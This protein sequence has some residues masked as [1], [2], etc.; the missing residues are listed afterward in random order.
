LRFSHGHEKVFAFI[1]PF[2]PFTAPVILRTE[3][4]VSVA[5]FAPLPETHRNF[6]A[7][8]P[9]AK[10]GTRFEEWFENSPLKSV[11]KGKTVIMDKARFRR[12]KRLEET[13]GN[14]KAFLLY[15]PPYSPD[16]NPI[17]KTWANR[18]KDLRNTAPLH[19]LLKTAI[20]AYLT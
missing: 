4:T 2:T 9:S 15:L 12:K 7:K 20:Y 1:F 16:L 8:C 6:R 19:K 10:K 3:E 18:N 5:S 14:H 11:G 13:G 17:E